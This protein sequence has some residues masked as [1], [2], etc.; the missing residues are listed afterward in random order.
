MPDVPVTAGL[1]FGPGPGPA[2]APPV[3][4]PLTSALASLNNLGAA[5]SPLVNAVRSQVNALSQAG[6]V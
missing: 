5:S 6:A 4:S 1:P 2:P 3:M